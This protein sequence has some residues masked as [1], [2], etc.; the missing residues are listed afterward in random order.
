MRLIAN[1]NQIENIEK[2][3]ALLLSTSSEEIKKQAAETMLHLPTSDIYK[4]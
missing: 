3:R 4:F 1:F 2:V